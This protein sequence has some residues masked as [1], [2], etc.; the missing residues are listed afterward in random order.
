MSVCKVVTQWKN[1]HLPP[2]T[3]C[4]R[5]TPKDDLVTNLYTLWTTPSVTIVRNS[6]VH[7]HIHSHMLTMRWSVAEILNRLKRLWI[8]TMGH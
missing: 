7:A 5:I 8:G 1:V 6:S 3:L 4:H 2:L